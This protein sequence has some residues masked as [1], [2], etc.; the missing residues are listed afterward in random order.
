MAL[1][2]LFLRHAPHRITHLRVGRSCRLA[3]LGAA[4]GGEGV[5][6]NLVL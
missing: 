2:C 1:Q 6:P 3:T 5:Q 4:L